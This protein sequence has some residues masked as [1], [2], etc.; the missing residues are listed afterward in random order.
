MRKDRAG[1]WQLWTGKHRAPG[2]YVCRLPCHPL[3]LLF[4]CLLS[5]SHVPCASVDLNVVQALSNL[6]LPNKPYNVGTVIRQILKAREPKLRELSNLSKIIELELVRLGSKPRPVWLR[7]P[8]SCS[9]WD[10]ASPAALPAPFKH[11]SLATTGAGLFLPP[12]RPDSHFLPCG[13]VRHL[14]PS[15]WQSLPFS[16][17][18]SYHAPFRARRPITYV[19][20]I[21]IKGGL[22]L[23]IQTFIYHRFMT[24]WSMSCVCLLTATLTVLC[25]C[26]CVCV[27]VHACVWCIYL[28]G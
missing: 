11:H 15:P 16:R 23:D 22:T 13:C 21:S 14:A 28:L 12:L 19:P 6:I 25:V 18:L 24:L 26:V 20:A 9:P 27:C 2:W 5:D 1:L 4:V 7:S 17:V 3:L 10:V 8:H